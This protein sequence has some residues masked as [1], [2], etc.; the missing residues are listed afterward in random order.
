MDVAPG[1]WLVV[2]DGAVYAGVRP[3]QPGCLGREAPIV[4]EQGPEGELWL[5]IY[6]CRGQALLGLRL[7]RGASGRATC[8]PATSWRSRSVARTLRRRR[9]WT[10]APRALQD[11]T[12]PGPESALVRSVTY[13]SGGDELRLRYDLWH[14]PPGP[15]LNG[16]PYHPPALRSPVAAQG[17][18]GA[19]GPGAPRCA[20]PPAVL[21]AGAGARSRVAG[22]GGRQP[23]GHADRAAPRGSAWHRH[24]VA[25]GRGEHR[26]AGA[27]RGSQ[28][29]VLDTLED[30][31]ELA[32]ARG[33][34]G[35]SGR[36][37]F[38]ETRAFWPRM[39]A[40]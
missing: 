33:G 35:D 7:L 4:L 30:P 40:R 22:L 37:A 9:S 6:R 8:A 23:P 12:G 25:L 19:R 31:A 36:L 5:T 16:L 10:C 13:G 38:E 20:P 3:L 2:A 27:R 14:P 39:A 28:T 34:A 26:V 15:C 17:S 32:R 18:S 24:R 21:A 1:E 11:E 29:L